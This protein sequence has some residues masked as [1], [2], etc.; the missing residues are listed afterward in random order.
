MKK[1]KADL[2]SFPGIPDYNITKSLWDLED[3]LS[4]MVINEAQP[5]IFNQKNLKGPDKKINSFISHPLLAKG[6]S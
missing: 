4:N 3:K 6:K 1:R 2:K 5:K